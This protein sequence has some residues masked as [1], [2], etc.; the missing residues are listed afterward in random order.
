M[1]SHIGKLFQNL[2]NYGPN[3]VYNEL[4]IN[5]VFSLNQ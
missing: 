1:L 5:E 3:E 2:P 4:N